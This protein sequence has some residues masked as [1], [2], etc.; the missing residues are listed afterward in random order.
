[1]KTTRFFFFIAIVLFFSNGYCQTNFEWDVIIDSPDNSKSELYSKSKLFIAET[2]K[3]AQDVIQNDDSESGVILVKAKSVQ[4]LY[5]QLNDHRWTFDYSI[6]FLMKDN[7]CRIIIDN[8]HCEAARAG[9]YEWPHMP[10]AD[11]Y[12]ETKGLIRTG[13][14][15]E[16]YLKVMTML[17]SELQMIVDSYSAYVRK[18]LVNDSNW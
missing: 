18:P 11:R 2:W 5:F 13:V 12:P 9:T 4:N 14:N 8:V 17:K 1:M 7:K 15:E 10:V 3:S 16:R 6:K